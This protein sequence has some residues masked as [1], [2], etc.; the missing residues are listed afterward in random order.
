MT[1]TRLEDILPNVQKPARYTG[2][3]LNV[4]RKDWDKA[5]IKIALAYP[6]AY[7]IGMSN[8]GIQI[9]YYILN[10]QPEVLA[11]RVFAPWPDMENQLTTCN[12]Q[13]TTLESGQPLSAFDI[14]GISLGH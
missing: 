6:D 5:A 7:E 11:E 12:L 13:L 8:L 4:I 14:F 2:N 10:Q 1:N 3:E 9:L